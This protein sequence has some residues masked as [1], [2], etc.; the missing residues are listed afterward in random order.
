MV[1]RI[2]SVIGSDRAAAPPEPTDRGPKVQR[3]IRESPDDPW[4]PLVTGRSGERKIDASMRG[5]GRERGE[6]WLLDRLGAVVWDGAHTVVLGLLA[7]GSG[8]ILA[9]WVIP[10]CECLNRPE[11]RVGSTTYGR[12]TAALIIFAFA[13]V[14]LVIRV[15]A[16]KDSKRARDRYH[17]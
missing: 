11:C 4:R 2:A 16:Y 12:A 5:N 8:I 13:I 14:S 7:A 9:L 10:I 17:S 15:R 1:V 3:P 6:F